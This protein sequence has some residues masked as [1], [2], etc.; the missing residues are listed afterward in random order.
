MIGVDLV[1]IPG[2][3]DQLG[4]PGSQF[5]QRVFTPGEL[6]VASSRGLLNDGT[7]ERGLASRC[8]ASGSAVGGGTVSGGTVSVGLARHLAGRWAAKEAFVKAWS[9]ALYGQ[10]PL[11]DRDRLD[12]R[13]IEV[14][15][16][17]YGRVSLQLRGEVHRHFHGRTW[18]LGTALSISHDGD[19][20]IAVVRLE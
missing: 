6:L 19:Y 1:Y 16:D 18:R 5:A 11:I 2:F 15:P 12:W 13:E 10:P 4:A 3:A 9:Q 20:A 8:P 14:V 17:A 7:A